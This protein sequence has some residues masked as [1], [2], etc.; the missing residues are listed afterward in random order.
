MTSQLFDLENY[1]DLVSL[2]A[3]HLPTLLVRRAGHCGSM[4]VLTRR[5]VESA[6]R[7]ET[8]AS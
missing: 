1:G 7:P 2:V 8:S 5:I 4:T 3:T 6:S